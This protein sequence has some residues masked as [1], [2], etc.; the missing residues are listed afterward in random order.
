MMHAMFLLDTNHFR[1]IATSTALGARLRSRIRGSS[2]VVVSC[3]VA[4]EESLRGWLA[5]LATQADVARQI[6]LYAELNAVIQCLADFSMLDWDA[7]CAARFKAFRKEGIRIGTMDL[8]IACI[9][10]EYDAVVLTRN[11]VDF[12]KVPAL[13]FENW[14]D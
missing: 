5:K 2:T 10:L 4:A 1:E 7:E 13:R 8:K 6:S 14:L 9:A 11:T 3:V 12:A